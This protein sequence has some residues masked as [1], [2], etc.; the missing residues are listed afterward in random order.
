[1]ARRYVVI[2]S[3]Q[4]GLESAKFR[5]IYALYVSKPKLKYNI[6]NIYNKY[7]ID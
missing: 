4:K 3:N 6:Y 1:M 5:G 2:I 7:N